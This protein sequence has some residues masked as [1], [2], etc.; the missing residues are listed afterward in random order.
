[1]KPEK[2]VLVCMQESMYRFGIV[3][4][5]KEAGY[6]VSVADRPNEIDDGVH[7]GTDYLLL[8]ECADFEIGEVVPMCIGRI[9]PGA[10]AIIVSAIK[11]FEANK[12][13]SLGVSAVLGFGTSPDALLKCLPLLPDHWIVNL[14]ILIPPTFNASPLTNRESQIVALLAQG[15]TVKEVAGN[16]DLSVKTVEAHKFNLMRKLGIHSKAELIHWFILNGDQ[17]ELEIQEIED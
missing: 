12:L 17:D 7:K 4:V 10:M 1:M 15:A 8:G 5:L 9:E 13:K 6:M 14:G 16:L 11:P 2:K 3:A